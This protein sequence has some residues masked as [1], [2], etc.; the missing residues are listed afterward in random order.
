[1]RAIISQKPE[2]IRQEKLN[3]TFFIADTFQLPYLDT[4]VNLDNLPNYRDSNATPISVQEAKDVAVKYFRRKGEAIRGDEDNHRINPD[5]LT[6]D[7]D[8]IYQ[9]ANGNPAEFLVSY[10]EAPFASS[11]HCY[12]PHKALIEKTKHGYSLTHRDFMSDWWGIMDVRSTRNE[13][14]IFAVDFDCPNDKPLRKVI[15]RLKY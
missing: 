4:T 15:V 1:M 11:S 10:W 14:D 6:I 9:L 7:F 13:D 3:D 8:T 2:I 5:I 12:W